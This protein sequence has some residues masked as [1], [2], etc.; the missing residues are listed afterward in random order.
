MT[1]WGLAYG[2]ARAIVWIITPPVLALT[3]LLADL[4]T[5]TGALTIGLFCAVALFFYLMPK[6]RIDWISQPLLNAFRQVVP[7]MSKTEK[8][9]LNAGNVWWDGALFS[10]QPNWQELLHHPTCHLTEEEQAYLD[11]PTQKLC[12]M[13]NDWQITHED[14]D[15][16]LKTW[17]AMKTCGMFGMIIPIQGVDTDQ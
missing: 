14:K 7:A 8:E 11:G 12:T 13:L 16:P 4:I 15:L 9:A 6:Q 5:M 2:S 1:L 17:K 10:G 3:L